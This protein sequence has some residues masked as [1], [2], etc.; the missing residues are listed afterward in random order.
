M[1]E[2]VTGLCLL[3]RENGGKT[4]VLRVT[5]GGK[6][7]DIGLGAYPS[8]TLAAAMED[9]RQKHKAIKEGYDPVI[10]R[11]KAKAQLKQEQ[12]TRRTFQAVAEN[13]IE[14]KTAEWK[15]PK[16]KSAW[17][18][19]LNTYAMPTIGSMDI[20]D[21]DTAHVLAILTPIWSTKTETARRVQGR[22]EAILDWAQAVKP[23]RTSEN[24]ARWQRHLSK[25]LPSPEKVTAVESHPAL[26]FNRLGEFMAALRISHYFYRDALEFCILTAV[27]NS[28]AT[29]AQWHEID[30]QAKTWTIPAE[31]LKIKD[32]GSH[33]V[34]LSTQA[35]AILQRRLNALDDEPTGLIFPAANG[36]KINE[37][38]LNIIVKK[39]GYGD[40][41]TTHG[42]RSTFKDWAAEKTYYP[43]EMTEQALAHTIASK[44]E[45]AYRR[46]DMLDKRIAMMQDYADFADKKQRRP[47]SKIINLL[48]SKK[49]MHQ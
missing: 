38:A 16:Q 48:D 35:Y 46:G 31:R 8:V 9:A 44:T 1:V 11:Q 49:A 34:P 33:T 10:E 18:N 43:N 41:A 21:I 5:V 2:G 30:H 29:G 45:Q 7:R 24:P 13:Y 40:I 12:Q 39:M 27:R 4:W 25:I 15:S 6:R 28:D 42:F 19:T 17:T 3:V 20:A 47:D 37:N 26:P 14:I 23:Y 22:I 36:K 32:K